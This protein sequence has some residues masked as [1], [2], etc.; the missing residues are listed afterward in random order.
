M[1][2]SCGAFKKTQ[3]VIWPEDDIIV[4]TP[5]KDK[6]LPEKEDKPKVEEKNKE[7]LVYSMVT[8]KGEE[9]KVPVHK[10]DFEIAVLLPFH[11]D[12]VNSSID[13][14]RS[15]VMLEYLQGMKLAVS[16]IE[17]LQSSFKIR[18]FDTDN[19]TNKL[20]TLLKK[21]VIENADLIIGPT[22][23]DQV[24]IAAYFAKKREIP[25]LSPMT[26]LN[27]LWSDNPYV[28]FLNPSDQMQAMEFLRY[29]KENHKD[30]KLL[31]VRDGK[32][33]DKTFGKALVDEC[34]AQKIEFEKVAYSKYLKWENHLGAEKTVIVHT[35]QSKT[36]LT[37]SVSGLLAKSDKITLIGS[38]KWMEFSNIDYG[39]LERLSVTYLSTSKAQVPNELS[40]GL[41]RNYRGMY[42]GVPSWHTYMGYDQLLFAC[43]TLDAFGKYFP[44]FIEGKALNYSNSNMEFK[45]TSSCFQNKYL[46]LYQLRDRE[47]I[48]FY[49]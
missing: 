12:S 3:P 36:N 35:T 1:L 34:I 37:F 46:Q 7:A 18:Y 45:K 38:D 23:E 47:I 28:F 20:K 27:K 10:K 11:T 41:I 22:D 39:Q 49:K 17:K 2:I 24:I 19:D 9:Y 6:D 31:I 13:K 4:V 42:K 43:E 48:P 16:E 40:T 15:D 32:Y 21:S 29:F 33:F 26:T 8:F 25:L 5:T 30:E 14:R 44:I